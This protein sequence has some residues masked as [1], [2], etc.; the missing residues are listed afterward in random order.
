MPS[1]ALGEVVCFLGAP[2]SLSLGGAEK[3]SCPPVSGGPRV[4]IKPSGQKE[5]RTVILFHLL[6]LIWLVPTLANKS[7]RTATRSH[8]LLCVSAHDLPFLYGGTKVCALPGSVRPVLV[9]ASH[10]S[11]KLPHLQP[12]SSQCWHT[13]SSGASWP[14]D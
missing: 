1:P 6:V 10:S 13:G 7:I 8:S 14:E 3:Q 9:I 5:S 2:A 12:A 4:D 11:Q